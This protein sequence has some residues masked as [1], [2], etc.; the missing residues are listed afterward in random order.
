MKTQLFVSFLARKAMSKK[1]GMVP[2]YCRVRYGDT[3]AQFSTKI[4]VPYINWDSKRTRVKGNSKKAMNLKL[5]RLRISIIEKYDAL[6]KTN[7]IITAKTIVDYYKN[8]TLIM[9]SV[10]NVFKQHNTNMKSL[11]GIEYSYGS[12][13][14]YKTT[15]KHLIKYINTKYNANDIFLNKINYDFIYNFSQF[16]LLH[17]ECNHNGMMKHIQRFKKITNFCINNNYITNDPFA[18]FKI[19]FKKSNRV[20]IN[21]QE[22]HTLKNIT[23]NDSLS[24]VRDI[25]LFACYTGLSYIDLYNLSLKN[26]RKGYDNLQWIYVKRHK[27]NIPSNIP[28]LPPAFS[29]LKKYKKQKNINR[30]FPMISNQKMNKALKEIAHLCNF[31]KKLTFHSARH[32]F[33]T[34]VTLTNGVPIETVSKMLGHNNIKTT[35]IYARVIDSKVSSDMLILREKFI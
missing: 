2:I 14:N 8:N 7:V 35:Q 9:N 31:N 10:I 1:T 17:T 25:F 4:D 12:Y 33:A 30:I 34:T 32:T 29:I 27:T 3:T 24:K 26:I 15:L 28:I 22:L 19:S 23:L 21:K 16:L 5:E 20:Y 11:I 13:K 6:I 18:G